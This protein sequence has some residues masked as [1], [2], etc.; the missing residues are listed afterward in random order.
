MKVNVSA[1]CI[2]NPI[3]DSIFIYNWIDLGDPMHTYA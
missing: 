2:R 3:P 1:W